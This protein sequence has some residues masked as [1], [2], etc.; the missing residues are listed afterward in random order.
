MAMH[1]RCYV[2]VIVIILLS[3][4]LC[5]HSYAPQLAS[6]VTLTTV[7]NPNQDTTQAAYEELHTVL[8]NYPQ[9][10]EIAT[11][12]KNNA[13]EIAI[14]ATSLP[15]ENNKVNQA[16]MQNLVTYINQA[17]SNI[18][19]LVR[20]T[21]VSMKFFGDIRDYSSSQSIVDQRMFIDIGIE[22]YMIPNN[23]DITHKF[24]DFNWR[25]FTINQPVK[26]SYTDNKTGS[27]KTIDVNYMS[28]VL[29]AE[30]P[31][32]MDAFKRAGATQQA[33]A[34]LQKPV[35]DYGKL[36]TSMDK[37]YV[38]FD[39]AA[40]LVETQGYG[41]KGEQNGARV[42]TIYSL[43]EG[44]IR[45]GK[46]EE[47][48]YD[49]SFGTGANTYSLSLTVPPPNA[50]IDV[51]GYSKMTTSGSGDSVA[52]ISDQNE[53]GSSYAGNFPLVVLGSLGGIMGGIT[54]FV[55]FKGR[56]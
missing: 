22:K 5:L 12:F 45:E 29:N 7:L 46:H 21:A 49:S 51:L 41:Y 43:G 35:L 37:W 48:I 36:S 6:A 27:I 11:L 24:V 32:F 38:L 52:V 4:D 39:P 16:A 53:G 31:G 30:I 47:T 13:R 8:I 26:L 55:L 15:T 56:K 1:K 54:G 2:F 44:S 40:S 28:G 10:S 18:H 3:F 23:Q 17:L 25:A 33:I 14:T 20:A 9:N 50:R 42:D 19:S 34:L